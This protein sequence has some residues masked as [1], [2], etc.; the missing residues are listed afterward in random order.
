MAGFKSNPAPRTK[1]WAFE[2]FMGLDSSRD[3]RAMDTGRQQHLAT[4]SNAFCDWRGQVVRDPGAQPLITFENNFPVHH[5]RHFSPDHFVFTEQ[6]G[7]SQRLVS[8]LGHSLDLAY[9]IDSVVTSTVFSRKVILASR[10]SI[11]RTYDGAV[12]GEVSSPDM[13]VSRPGIITSVQRRVAVSGIPG[14]ETEVHF[15]RVDNENIF[16]DDEDDDDESVLRAGIIDVAN[17]IGT[18]DRITGLAPFEQSRLAIFTEDRTLIYKIDPDI[19]RWQIDEAANIRVGCIS[20]NTVAS[21]GPDLLFCSRFGIHSAQRSAA[22]G[23]FVSSVTYSDKIDVLY[24]SLV[25]SVPDP[26]MISA[27]FDND[28]AQYH[29]FF[30]QPGGLLTHRLTMSMTPELGDDAVPKFSTATFL[31][32]RCGAYLAGDLLVGTSGGVYRVLNEE[33]VVEDAVYPVATITTPFLWHGSLSEEKQTHSLILQ[34]SGQGI[35]EL[36]AQDD[37]GRVLGSMRF[38]IDDTPDDNSF[39]DVPLSA[40]Y[41]RMWQ[42]RY[43]AAKYRIRVLESSGLVRISGLAIKTRV[44]S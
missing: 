8:S 41:E 15:S 22:N 16:P 29:V 5:I 14:R 44:G 19:D 42:H 25:K 6:D 4:M 23:I 27:V 40:Q 38:E 20:H 43:R 21:A 30:P 1:T 9:P 10:G 2:E 32:M 26:R 11:M 12:F 39:D 33:D 3:I 36:D 7:A 34:A 37:K 35:I 24:R 13:S 18:A 17:L 28:R 31:N